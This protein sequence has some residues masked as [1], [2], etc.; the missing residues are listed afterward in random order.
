MTGTQPLPAVEIE[1]PG[2]A[3]ASVIWL[4]GLGAD[5]HDFEPIVPHLDLPPACNVR[6][7]FPHAP[8]RPV[9]INNGMVMPAWYDIS[10]SEFNRGEDAQGIRESSD[11]VRRFIARE[12]E[13]GIDPSRIVL[14]GF[15][16]G[17]AIALHTGL[18]FGQPL[19]GIMALSTYLP[20]QDTL[21][22][23]RSAANQDTPILMIHG[24]QD[25][26]VPPP[27]A[28]LSRQYLES[29]GYSLQWREF[30]MGHSVSNEEIVVIS[31]WLARRL[32]GGG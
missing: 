8:R 2:A 9:T 23:E 17:G 26:V 5:G 1:P 22:R 18:R 6:F 3:R 24:R 27:L 25:N 11:T 32:C 28:H 13:R 10:G 15:S 4:H 7:I 16:Q 30:D 19:A 21:E 14:A 31:R 29:L 20:L 12:T